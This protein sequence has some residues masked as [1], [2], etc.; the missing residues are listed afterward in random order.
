MFKEV[1]TLVASLVGISSVISLLINVLKTV[2]VV[3]DGTAQNWSAGANL[4]IVL[5]VYS[6]RLFKP[7][8]DVTSFDPIFAE[9]ATV[10]SFVFAYVSSLL[11]SK[12][13]YYAVKGLPVVGKSFTS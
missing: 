11:T 2:G 4:V 13:T 6:L 3:K 8:I 7:E 12:L 5:I 10:G 9:I 1:L